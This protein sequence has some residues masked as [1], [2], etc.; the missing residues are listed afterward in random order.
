MTKN[1]QHITNEEH[2]IGRLGGDEFCIVIA[3]DHE[4][5]KA[6]SIAIA[7]LNSFDNSIFLQQYK[8]HTSFS[9]GIAQFPQHADN[10]S[11]LLKAADTA[12]YEAKSKGRQC[13]EIYT[14]AL[15][16]KI[17]SRIGLKK[18]LN[19]AYEKEQ[20]ELYYQPQ[21]SLSTQKIIGLEALIR[22]IHP[23][24]GIIMPDQ[25]IDIAE[26]TRLIIKMGEWVL[27]RACLD[28]QN[29]HKKG[30]KINVAVNVSPIQLASGNFCHIVKKALEQSGIAPSY[31]EIEIT[32]SSFQA[33]KDNIDLFNR[34]HQLGIKIAI[35]DFGTGYSNLVSISKLPI[36][37]LKIDRE[38]I[39]NI[40]ADNAAS[41]LTA[42]IIGM[43]SIKQLK[44]IAEGIENIEQIQYLQAINCDYGQGYFIGKPMEIAQVS[45]FLKRQL[46]EQ[47]IISTKL[48][49]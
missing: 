6:R 37:V 30:L 17:L 13:Y 14:D 43:A 2:F 48:K 45:M 10:V 29:L 35:D 34:L 44:V 38:F 41:A 40:P 49:Q 8:I 5:T 32:E 12:M 28:A 36:D 20:F 46:A 9:I 22:W 31:L 1:L 16:K 39:K 19:D 21:L 24:K 15:S 3:N 42:S 11:G 47:N 25:F 18:E 27:N 26:E 33:T 4:N 23:T 7:I